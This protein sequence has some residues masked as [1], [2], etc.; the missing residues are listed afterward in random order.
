MHSKAHAATADPRAWEIIKDF[1]SDQLNF[2]QMETKLKSYLGDR[3]QH[4]D[5]NPVFVVLFGTEND[6]A[7]AITLAEKLERTALTGPPM[8]KPNV[9]A[10]PQSPPQLNTLEKD[11][12]ASV[13]ELKKRKR[14]IGTA[15]TLEDLLNPIEENETGESNFHFPGGDA[16]IVAQVVEEMGTGKGKST[17]EVD[18]ESDDETPKHAEITHQDVVQLCQQLERVCIQRAGEEDVE[19]V[20]FLRRFRGRLWRDELRN[21]QQVTLER[22]WQAKKKD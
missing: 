20:G 7:A 21:A 10:P 19:L 14:I 9:S 4:D 5:W 18:S 1:A 3:Y 16:D 13:S 2:V 6:T 8:P 15:P 22:F 11:L 17:M 12:L